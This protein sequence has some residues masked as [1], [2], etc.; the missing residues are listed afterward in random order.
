MRKETLIT[1]GICLWASVVFGQYQIESDAM[2]GCDL[3]ECLD[4][5]I[6]LAN[7]RSRRNTR[8]QQIYSI[9]N[10]NAA[11]FVPTSFVPVEEHFRLTGAVQFIEKVQIFSS[12]GMLIYQTSLPQNSWDGLWEGKPQYG[13]FKYR[14][15]V[16]VAA[17]KTEIIEGEV[18]TEKPI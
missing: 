16:R 11:L 14:L 7:A 4:A 12:E 3:P 10:L 8:Q 6:R 17:D 13:I 18:F 15:I 5:E 9:E 2:K 1:F